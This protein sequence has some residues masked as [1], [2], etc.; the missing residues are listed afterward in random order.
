MRSVQ[1]PTYHSQ[2]FTTTQAAAQTEL[3]FGA[4]KKTISHQDNSALLKTLLSTSVGEAIKPRF[5]PQINVIAEYKDNVRTAKNNK[6]HG[7]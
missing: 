7:V 3:H 5:R 2:L 6:L 1:N 4:R